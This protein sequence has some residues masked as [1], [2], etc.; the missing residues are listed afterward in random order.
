MKLS[1]TALAST[2]NAMAIRN[3]IQVSGLRAVAR[4]PHGRRRQQ[5]I[6]TQE[7]HTKLSS[8]AHHRTRNTALTSASDPNGPTLSPILV[9]ADDDTR[10]F[11]ALHGFMRASRQLDVALITSTVASYWSVSVR[12]AAACSPALGAASCGRIVVRGETFT[13]TIQSGHAACKEARGTLKVF[14]AGGGTEHG[15]RDAPSYKKRG[16]CTAAGDAASGLGAEAAPASTQRP[17]SSPSRFAL[18]GA[19]T[20]VASRSPGSGLQASHRERRPPPRSGL[21]PQRPHGARAEHRSTHPSP[22]K[23]PAVCRPR[24]EGGGSEAGFPRLIGG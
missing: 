4:F 3:T 17:R 2:M 14:L 22:P 6:R 12:Y 20:S 13:T 16:P 10:P 21:P 15:G 23:G 24:K 7:T 9:H 19:S 5:E 8:T 11:V 1:S 18:N